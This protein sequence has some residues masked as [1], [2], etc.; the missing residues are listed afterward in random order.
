MTVTCRVLKISTSGYYEWRSRRPSARDVEDAHLV[1]LLR[2]VHA[3]S[4]Q[5]YGVRRCH[6][7]LRLGA[8]LRVGH[9]RVWRLLRLAGLQGV[10][11]RRWRHHTPAQAVWEDRV[12]RKFRAD[13]PNKLWFTDITQ[14]RTREGWVY[15]AAVLDVY[16]RR[17]VGWSI[18]D[19]IRTELVVDALQMARWQRRPQPG[20]IVHADRGTQYTSWLFGHRLRAAGLLG[21]MGRVASSVDNA[22]VESFWSTM[23]RELLDRRTWTSRTELA[24]AM[25]E[26]IEA[27]YNPRRRHSALGYLSP[28]E[29]EAL[30][31]AANIAA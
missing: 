7:E 6:A 30:H 12:Q 26:W 23:Q 4:R 27:W 21:S 2:A 20:T 28:V 13:G 11:R 8:G 18:A 1:H 9:K 5:T 29:Y 3:R 17:V 15:C 19:H 24:S 22:L 14:H 25:F 31:S 10:H 16:S